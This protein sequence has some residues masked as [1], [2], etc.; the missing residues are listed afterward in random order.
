[1]RF[2][3]VFVMAFD[4]FPKQTAQTSAG[5]VA[6]GRSWHLNSLAVGQR[7]DYRVGQ[8]IRRARGGACGLRLP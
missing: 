8:V 7:H 1:M 2:S 4:A 3:T 6:Y 5:L